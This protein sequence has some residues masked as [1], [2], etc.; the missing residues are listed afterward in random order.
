MNT[1][2]PGE[3]SDSS[4]D[5]LLGNRIT[6]HQ[7][8]NGYR[9]AIDPVILAAAVPAKPGE[10]VLD[11]GC[12][13]GAAALCLAARV[14]DVAIA[15]LEIQSEMIR[16]ALRNVTANDVKA[17]VQ[18]MQGDISS[19]PLEIQDRIFDHVMTNPP[20]MA[21]GSG[22]PPPDPVRAMATVEGAQGIEPWIAFP[23]SILKHKGTLTMIHRADRLADILSLMSGRFGDIR[24]Y[25]LWPGPE[26]DK[27]AKRV[28]VQA[29][30][31]INAPLTLLPGMVLHRED[32]SY[33]P[34]AE[35]V[36][37]DA[38]AISL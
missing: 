11:V 12:G 34:E 26:A 21:E 36:L 25:P 16:Y 13:T 22:N 10:Q 37:A 35:A 8:V 14:P 2:T 6:L 3:C 30:K 9:V 17:R 15:G 18:I 33:T 23:A 31:G 4:R 20:F 38:E 29:R 24:V 19:P 5:Q 28:M 27:P 32:G 7:P 1:T